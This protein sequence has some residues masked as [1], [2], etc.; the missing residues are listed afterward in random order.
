MDAQSLRKKSLEDISKYFINS[1]EFKRKFNPQNK[2]SNSDFVKIIYKNTFNRNP[3][4]KDLSYWTGQMSKDKTRTW[5]IVSL[6]ESRE[7]Q[8]NYQLKVAESLGFKAQWLNRPTQTRKN[9]SIIVVAGQSNAVGSESYVQQSPAFRDN[10]R[11]YSAYPM[12]FKIYSSSDKSSPVNIR[13]AQ[14]DGAKK[15]IFGPEIGLARTMYEKGKRDVVIVKVAEG[16]TPLHKRDGHDWNIASS[17]ENYD[18]MIKQVKIASKWVSDRGATYQIDGLIWMQGETDTVYADGA[19]RYYTNIDNLWQSF[20]KDLKTQPNPKMVI[21]KIDLRRHWQ[22]RK[23]AGNCAPSNPSTCSS[24][25]SNTAK[26]QAAQ[27]AF[28][29]NKSDVLIVPTGDLSVVSHHQIH[30]S[31]AGQ[32][33]LGKRFAN[34]FLSAQ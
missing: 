23:K 30:Y 13:T 1:A 16:G 2:Q 28:A 3:S 19:N 10:H 21:G 12:S 18:D 15:Q 32:M 14:T 5:V 31:A 6:T 26:V 25:I 8:R 7:A 9:Y 29:R 4:S 24:E 22:A 11:A 33:E 34:S 20:K 27:E 17:N